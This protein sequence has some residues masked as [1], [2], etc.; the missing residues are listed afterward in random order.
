MPIVQN[1]TLASV[2]KANVAMVNAFFPRAKDW[3]YPRFCGSYTVSNAVEPLVIGG[4]TP[5]LKVWNG[6]VNSTGI[7]SYTMQVP[8]LLSKNLVYV[9]RGELELDQTDT[10]MKYSQQFGIALA[11]YPDQLWAKR[12]LA[13]SAAN[14]QY[15]TFNGVKYTTTFDGQPY[16]STSH[17]PNNSAGLA[18]S[19]I[20]A[21]THPA[22]IAGIFG[23]D[24]GTTVNELQ[25]A[26]QNVINNVMTVQN[27]QGFPIYQTFDAK[28]S[29]V[30]IVPPCLEV[31]AYLAFKTPSSIVGG[32][33][34]GSTGSTTNVMPMFV[35]D[36]VSSGLLAGF[37]DPEGSAGV[38]IAPVNPTDFYVAIVDDW[39]KPFYVQLFKPAGPND[40]FPKDWNVDA[41]IES[42]LNASAQ[43]GLKVSR[44]AA[45]LFSSSIVE[46]N[47]GAV[48]NSAQQDVVVNE[49]FFFSSRFRGNV[50][51]G[52]WFTCWR[53]HGANVS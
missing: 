24:I 19:N 14:S 5:P 27:N 22:S 8:S 7:P 17:T 38:L 48:G 34:S 33:A 4:A 18:Q 40:L 13:G 42:M 1:T 43:S 20:I 10:L 47:I 31:A 28:K 39:V 49:R 25:L 26:V 35:K 23:Q 16:F 3:L 32:L 41:S 29:I 52:P 36:V 15:T 6:T 51:Y 30:V 45:T 9:D 21:G 50:A 11:D 46:T 2:R 37:P 12:L 53:V 44:D